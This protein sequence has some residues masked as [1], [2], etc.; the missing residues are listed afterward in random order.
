MC[1]WLLP[2]QWSEALLKQTEEMGQQIQTRDD[3]I[4]KID[5]EMKPMKHAAYKKLEM[6]DAISEV[7]TLTAESDSVFKYF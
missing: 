2:V 4:R 3:L 6:L 5:E 1:L 7:T